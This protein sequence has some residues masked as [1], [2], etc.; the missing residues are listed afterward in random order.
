MGHAI[1][2]KIEN[3]SAKY[4]ESLWQT[5]SQFENEPS[6]R[7]LN[8]P[9]HITMAIYEN[10][11]ESVLFSAFDFFAN[12]LSQ[13]SITFNNLKTFETEK[14][15]VLWAQPEASKKLN[16]LHQEIHT[17]LDP[18]LCVQNYRPEFW[19]PHCTLATEIDISRKNDVAN[20]LSDT[21]ES[22]VVIFDVIDCVSLYPIKVVRDKK[23]PGA[24]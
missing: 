18:K 24:L 3:E 21:V 7:A 16:A 22:I 15:I 17:M 12:E 5:S 9:P 23:L 2:I 13:I 10:I 6:M 11:S 1:A 14:T 20:L 19:I 4:I 8:Y